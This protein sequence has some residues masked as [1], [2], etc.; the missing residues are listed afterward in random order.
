MVDQCE[1]SMRNQKL[2]KQKF[3]IDREKLNP[4]LHKVIT[5]DVT[6]MYSSINVVRTVSIILD[7]NYESPE[8]IFKFKNTDGNT[9]PPPKRENLKQFL[10]KTLQKFCLEFLWQIMRKI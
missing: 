7:K 8:K 4:D 5:V 2:F 9:L 6:K 10:I 3:S 1:F